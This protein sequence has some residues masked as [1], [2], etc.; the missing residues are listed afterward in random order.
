MR[1]DCGAS[2]DESLP[3]TEG[4]TWE[5]EYDFIKTGQSKNVI[6]TSIVPQ[7]MRTLRSFPVG[8]KN[9]YKFQLVSDLP[10]KYLIRAG[11]YYGNYDGLSKP[12]VFDLTINGQFWTRISSNSS[13]DEVQYKELL[14]RVKRDR[15]EV[16]LVRLSDDDVP[17]ISSFE[18]FLLSDDRFYTLMSNHS[19]LLLQSRISFGGDVDVG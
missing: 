19:T 16:C 1:I 14:Y 15:N 4:P 13:V 12:P 9:C 18:A 5:L 6:N 17:F 11:F 8:D 2:T 3:T 10:N 7:E